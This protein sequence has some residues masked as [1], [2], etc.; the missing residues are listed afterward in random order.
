M[1]K[2]ERRS[3][4]HASHSAG[5]FT[6]VDRTTLSKLGVK[7][8]RA[9][10]WLRGRNVDVPAEIYEV[11]SPADG[12]LIIRLGM[13]D[14][15]VEGPVADRLSQE[16]GVG[17]PGAYRVE[18]QDAS[19]LLKGGK[20]HDV[21]AQMCSIDFH[22]LARD[23]VCLTR[24]AAV[25]CM[26]LPGDEAGTSTFRFWCDYTLGG[27]LWESLEEITRDVAGALAATR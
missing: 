2:L 19:F 14:F 13:T 16:L 26:I 12:S 27:S 8:P 10:E 1:S 18:R 21:L 25:N 23:R 11:R 20:A 17:Q 22:S 3:P 9:E 4:I 15:L 6:V 7:G 5:P 24:A